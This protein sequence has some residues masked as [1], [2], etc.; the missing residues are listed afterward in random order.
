MQLTVTKQGHLVQTLELISQEDLSSIDDIHYFIG[1]SQECH[2]VIDTPHISRNH[3]QLSFVSKKWKLKKLASHGNLFLNGV[4]VQESEI[5][6]GDTIQ[7]GE[8][9][10]GISFKTE[11]PEKTAA[12]PPPSDQEKNSDISDTEDKP[13][14]DPS[15]EISDER[16]DI[17][18]GPSLDLEDLE[19]EK[20]EENEE[21]VEDFENFGE[22]EEPSEYNAGD[23]NE[24]SD[25]QGEEVNL[26]FED[27]NNFEDS[28]IEEGF[29]NSD[30]ETQIVQSFVEFELDISGE[31]SN[32]DKYYIK[33]D[34][35]FIGRDPNKCQIVLDDPECSQVHAS[36]RR[37]GIRCELED[38]K[39]TNGI[40]L[41]GSRINQSQ[42]SN[43]DEFLIGSTSFRLRVKSE[44][45]SAEKNLLMPVQDIEEVEVEKIVEEE[46]ENIGEN[47][48]ILL[49]SSDGD[50]GST[51][52][53]NQ[54]FSNSLLKDPQKR[55]KL[56]IYGVVLMGLWIFLDEEKPKPKV[57]SKKTEKNRS[58]VKEK[59]K[60]ATPKGENN[61]DPKRVYKNLPQDIQ[62]YVRT[63]YELAKT[64]ILDY[65][66]FEYGLRYLDKI[67]E[68]VD[69]FEQSKSLS[70]TAKEE[71]KKLEE[72]EKER[73]R[74]QEEE[75]KK[76]KVS[77]FLEK[78]NNAFEK[79]NVELTQAL[80]D[81]V[82]EI[83][84]ENLEASQIKLQLDAFVREK[85]R[86]ALEE[87]QKKQRRNALLN[88]LNPGKV[89]Y[90][91][92]KWYQAI[93]ELEKFLTIKDN[94]EDLIQ[95]SSKMLKKSQDKL[96]EKIT[97]F[98][99]KARSLSEG[100]D[101]K[102]SYETYKDILEID[103][104]NVEAISKMEKIKK[105]IEKQAKK[106]YR[107]AIIDESLNYLGKAKEKLNEVQQ[108]SPSDSLYYKRSEN[109]LKR[110]TD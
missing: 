60:K 59:E 15:D 12:D 32:F 1:R 6:N 107:E 94:D 24:D 77:S 108:I 85:E 90:L 31:Y 104:S 64:E 18:D 75:E 21:V 61:K 99:Q 87:V 37:K 62:E 41:N 27:E 19:E 23:E 22:E 79:E 30:E 86:K 98:L 72:I 73:K 105:K 67:D 36:I 50:V 13:E 29:D 34:E 8:Y 66:N 53:N 63:N 102:G 109:K 10:I 103:P 55:K 38:L 16:D 83:D 40:I 106:I 11:E 70:I 9:H 68:Y 97:P 51:P 71:L 49:G 5:K 96:K 47:T 33:N 28:P 100:Q 3:A 48:D 45:I 81:K 58:L 56:L 39:S 88:K 14:N 54:K 52:N 78:A 91:K 2:V 92:Q 46:V 89:L 80:L 43:G 93:L 82:S 74:K 7:C 44:L 101:L 25:T 69:E 26:S 57:S 84:P 4:P 20:E 65:G 76:I 17:D 110:Y 35:I 42:L 95:E